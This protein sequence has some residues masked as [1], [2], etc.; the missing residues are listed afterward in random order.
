GVAAEPGTARAPGGA[1]SRVCRSNRRNE[2]LTSRTARPDE[3]WLHVKDAPGAPVILQPAGG[4]P[5]DDALREAAELAAYFSRARGSSRVPVDWTRVKHA[6]EPKGARPGMVVYD[7]HQ[8]ISVPPGEEP[9]RARL[10]PGPRPPRRCGAT[11]SR[12]PA[13]PSPSCRPAPPAA[14]A[15]HPAPAA[16]SP[17]PAVAPRPPPAPRPCVCPC[18][19]AGRSAAGHWV[20][21]PAGGARNARH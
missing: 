13:A 5:S 12:R 7:H 11:R 1:R 10:Q 20:A 2:Q 21:N 3:V 6:R 18:G 17:D 19:S 8:P 9:V 4:E 15:P 14:P 16:Q